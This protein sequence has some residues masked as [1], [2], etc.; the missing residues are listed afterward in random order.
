MY[1][2]EETHAHLPTTEI[3]LDISIAEKEI[4]SYEKE[5]EILRNNPTENKLAIYM[6][7]GKI[8]IRKDF[9][10]KLNQILEYRK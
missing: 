6:R 1:L 9:I 3:E 2:T 4:N 7:Q 10:E 8:A 5:L